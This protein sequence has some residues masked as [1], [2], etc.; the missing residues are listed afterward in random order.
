M[1]PLVIILSLILVGSGGCTSAPK[2]T[3]EKIESSQEQL[4]QI[5][6]IGSQLAS[7]QGTIL[8][9]TNS[10]EVSGQ[11]AASVNAIAPDKLRLEVTNFL[12]GS[13]ALISI[14]GNR[15]ELRGTR[16]QVDQREVGFG[17]WGGIPLNWA[18]D[19]FLGKFP[20]PAATSKLEVQTDSQGNLVALIAPAPDSDGQKFIYHLG[21]REGKVWPDSLHWERLGSSAV[22]VD[23]KFDDPESETL[24]PKKW[25]ANSA[26]GLV[27]IRWKDRSVSKQPAN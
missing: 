22:V 20:C 19:L 18:T 11:F 26:K 4:A 25:E 5:C 17:S 13:E 8:I 14:Q 9:K 12:G 15:Y 10:K 1:N 7:S 21:E 24:S 2:K 27:K 23:F 6:S 16:N 3:E